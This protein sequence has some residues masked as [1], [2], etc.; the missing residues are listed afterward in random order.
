MGLKEGMYN[1]SS[2]EN[3]LGNGKLRS[4]YTPKK[5]VVGTKSTCNSEE[6]LVGT[7]N[8]KAVCTRIKKKRQPLAISELGNK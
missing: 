1:P 7:W 4:E 8:V 2:A 3:P 6:K 5:H